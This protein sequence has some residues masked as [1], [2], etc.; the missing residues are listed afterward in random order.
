MVLA[1]SIVGNS[2]LK[3]FD[4]ARHL[5]RIPPLICKLSC[6]ALFQQ[7]L[8]SLPD[9]SQC[10]GKIIG[11]DRQGKQLT[12]VPDQLCL[13]PHLLRVSVNRC[14]GSALFEPVQLGLETLDLILDTS[15]FLRTSRSVVRDSRL[16]DQYLIMLDERAHLG[17]GCLERIAN[18][19]RLFRDI[20]GY[21][22]KISNS[23]PLG[24]ESHSAINELTNKK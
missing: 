6:P 24:W 3:V 15:E 8:R 2:I 5:A 11:K 22:D 17:E 16:T 20:E 19:C 21:L 13:F 12:S 23:L 14:R 1:H 4:K 18:I 7:F 9:P 10:A